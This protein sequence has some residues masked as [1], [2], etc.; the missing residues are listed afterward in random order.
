MAFPGHL[1]GVKQLERVR[2]IDVAFAQRLTLLR[3]HLSG[4]RSRPGDPALHH[5]GLC[6][7]VPGLQG[8]A[9][10]DSQRSLDARHH[11]GEHLLCLVGA[12]GIQVQA[13]PAIGG[14][15]CSEI[16]IT[17][18]R[19]DDTIIGSSAAELIEPGSGSDSI[20]GGGGGD[21]TAIA[22]LGDSLLSGHL[23]PGERFDE[24]WFELEAGK[25][26]SLEAVTYAGNLVTRFTVVNPL[27]GVVFDGT[28]P[29]TIVPAMTGVYRVI[30]ASASGSGDYQLQIPEPGTGGRGAAVDPFDN[31]GL[32]GVTLD[33][34]NGVGRAAPSPI[35]S[36]SKVRFVSFDRARLSIQE[37]ALEPL[38]L[39]R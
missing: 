37:L 39:G 2:N 9:M 21:L 31:G 28:G 32:A 35:L 6:Q 22:E 33:D 4:K 19:G 17:T 14:F 16:Q 25:S 7:Q 26:F 23:V 12:T 15:N 5:H 3:Q 34:A 30:V 27:G 24:F 20:Y 10:L 1:I 29:F 8:A 18:G 38:S 36:S 13:L 11:T